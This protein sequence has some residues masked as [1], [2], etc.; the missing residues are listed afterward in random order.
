M[1]WPGGRTTKK[2]KKRKRKEDECERKGYARQKAHGR[3]REAAEAYRQSGRVVAEPRVAGKRGESRKR[4]KQTS[5][6]RQA[7]VLPVGPEIRILYKV[8]FGVKCCCKAF[9]ENPRYLNPGCV[10]I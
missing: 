10:S 4:E 1:C 5:Q 3:R 2:K 6:G 7:V 9:Y 8:E